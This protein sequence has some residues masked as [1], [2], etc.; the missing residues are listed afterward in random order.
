MINVKLIILTGLWLFL[1]H[2]RVVTGQ[3]DESVRATQ[4]IP[5]A[6][7]NSIAIESNIAM[8]VK[9][10]VIYFT[11]RRGGQKWN[12]GDSDIYYAVRIDNSENGAWSPPTPLLPPLNDELDQDEVHISSGGSI[13]TY[14]KWTNDWIKEG[15]P[16][17]QVRRDG[18]STW[19]DA[20]ALGG[21][22]T[23][24][25]QISGNTASDGMTRLADGSM[26]FAA[27]VA[28]ETAMDLYYAKFDGATFLYPEPLPYNTADD[29][30]SVSL[31]GDGRTLFF[32]SNRKG[33]LGGMDIYRVSLREDG[34]VETP[35]NLGK[36]INTAANESGL[37]I[38]NEKEGYFIRDGDIYRIKYPGP[39]V[40]PK[41]P[42]RSA[43]DLEVA[44]CCP[45]PRMDAGFISPPKVPPAPSIIDAGSQGSPKKVSNGVPPI[46]E[47]KNLPAQKP[48]ISEPEYK[49]N[50]VVFLLDVS[51]TM[52]D[53]NKF[54]LIRKAIRT[55]LNYYFSR[56]RVT[57][58][59][60]A[61][62]PKTRLNGMAGNDRR[63]ISQTL[64]S[65]T[66]GGSNSGRVALAEAIEHA[67][68]Y[69]LPDGQN[70]II[71]VT[72][73]RMNFNRLKQLAR[74]VREK[75]ILWYTLVY[76]T[77]D[78]AVNNQLNQLKSIAGGDYFWI[79]P[80]NTDVVM[81][82]ILLLDL[83]KE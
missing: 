34:Q 38:H 6:K 1:F 58:I 27:G 37:I 77:P 12:Q 21:G 35:Q 16:Y 75:G 69:F 54:P 18:T 65:I 10:N 51:H 2:P 57:I 73:S 39:L 59:T 66:T 62:E 31:S 15:G 13:L 14:Q 24:F 11:T 79:R 22:I 67:E 83:R 26:I 78:A 50:N 40:A 43:E 44:S 60:F 29:E 41:V 70:L 32:A 55:G 19:T 7:L 68:T 46:K 30:R 8:P 3:T 45:P 64:T 56:D 42:T 5:E 71:W 49:P 17:F 4:V 63:A 20:V 28:F 23:E 76:G 72:D 81:D 53:A 36:P 80:E 61:D 33:G 9:G 47:S 82:K 74:R 25:F 48:A 52:E